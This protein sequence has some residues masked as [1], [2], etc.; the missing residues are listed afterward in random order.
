M[1]GRILIADKSKETRIKL[2][3]MTK[4]NGIEADAVSG[5]EESL[6]QI[7]RKDYALMLIGTDLDDSDGFKPIEKIRSRQIKTPIILMLDKE[8]EQDA[9]YGLSIGADDLV[10]KSFSIPILHAKI[11]ALIR[12]SRGAFSNVNNVI[13]ALPFKFNTETMQLFKDDREIQLSGKEIL[14]A[15][16]FMENVGRLFSKEMIYEMIWHNDIVDDNEV[17]V[18]INHLRQKIEDNPKRPKY[19]KTVRGIGYKFVV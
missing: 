16:L 13:T 4:I 14:I 10:I 3:I 6:K 5:A 19:L 18:Y 1:K 9:L 12:R 11:N 17:S 2:C 7:E 15:K 8:R